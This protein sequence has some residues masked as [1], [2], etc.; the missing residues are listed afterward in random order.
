MLVSDHDNLV[1]VVVV[2]V[3]VYLRPSLL[4]LKRR[5]PWLWQMPSKNIYRKPMI[6]KA[7]GIQTGKKENAPFSSLFLWTVLTFSLCLSSLLLSVVFVHNGRHNTCK[8]L[9][10]FL[11]L[12]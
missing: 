8:N 4:S 7:R 11:S 6:E 5:V 10:G 2:V 12:E 1:V 3:V 9:W